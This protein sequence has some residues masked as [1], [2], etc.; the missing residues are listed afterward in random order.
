MKRR[1]K[2]SVDTSASKTPS[3]FEQSLSVRTASGAT[4]QA[5]IPNSSPVR[6]E[7][8]SFGKATPNTRRKMLMGN[9]FYKSTAD[10]AMA[11][12]VLIIYVFQPG[13]V[14]MAFSTL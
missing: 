1:P 3:D 4:R 14:R 7:E 6:V 8:T 13:I 12:H 5:Q 10:C 2:L 11:A 9:Y